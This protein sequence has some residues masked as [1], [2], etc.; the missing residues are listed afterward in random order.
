MKTKDLVY[1]GVVGVLAYLLLRKKPA[2]KDLESTTST[3]SNDTPVGNSTNGGLNLGS[4]MDLPN[5]TPTPADG[6]STEVA[7]SSSNVNPLI[8]EDN[9]PTQIFGGVTLPPPYMSTSVV[10]PNPV[11]VV[12]ASTTSSPT[13][14]TTPTP[15]ASTTVSEVMTTEPVG[16]VGTT[17]TPTATGGTVISEPYFP[18]RTIKEDL[19]T[20]NPEVNP[21]R[22]DITFSSP[23]MSTP[24][25]SVGTNTNP[26][27]TGGTVITEP[28][29]PIRTIQEDLIT[30]KPEANPIRDDFTFSPPYMSTPID[31]FGTNTNSIVTGG[32]VIAEPYFPI[33][34]I[35]AEL[36]TNQPDMGK[37]IPIIDDVTDEMILEC[38]DS[39]SI[40][41]TDKE[42]SYTNFWF[43]GKE[44]YTQTTSPLIKSLPVKISKQIYA[45]A[46]K[47]LQALKMNYGNR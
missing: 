12:P 11:D 13:A 1:L 31:Y 33:R 28:Y 7:L 4:N 37:A 3:S 39:F 42:G 20:I 27:V 24:L 40:A 15:T 38:G 32:T 43:D 44:Y 17:S 26:T 47:K 41:N 46:C 2:S 36:V 34:T 23:Y 10:N 30:I 9:E 6:L 5:L 21:I 8:K 19:I 14:S 16:S 35:K 29:L 25:D 22:D 45:D 18:I